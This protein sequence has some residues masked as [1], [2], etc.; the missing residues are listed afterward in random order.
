MMQERT[1]RSGS[2]VLIGAPATATDAKLVS[3]MVSLISEYPCISEA[4]LPLCMFPEIEHESE[5]VLVII[6]E[7]VGNAI[8]AASAIASTLDSQGEHGFH[9]DIWPMSAA[10]P[11]LPTIRGAKCEIMRR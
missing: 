3:Q 5:V 8:L 4:H 6:S 9:L 11:L 1:Y 10:D 7:V 2:K